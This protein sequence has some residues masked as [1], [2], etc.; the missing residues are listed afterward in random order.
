MPQWVTPDLLTG[1]G[2]AGAFAIFL[3]YALSGLGEEWLWLAIAG[4]VAQWFGDS[5][6][7]SLARYRKIERP[8]F[9]FFIDHSCDG[10]T[11]LLILMGIGL[12]PYVQIEAA[13]ITLAGYL[14]LS[15]HA[16]LATHVLGEMRL[17]YLAMGPTELRFALIG[18]TL[19]MMWLGYDPGLF[20]RISGFDIMFAG[21][22][23]ILIAIFVVQ[24]LKTARQL[25]TEESRRG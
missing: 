10:L 17:S 24:T 1:F 7:G 4:Y 19:M 9:G 15:I 2:V 6:D 3:G 5:M 25:A 12:S 11:L 18:T 16:Y 13:L 23:G 22:G 21:V 8:R 14:L 20:G